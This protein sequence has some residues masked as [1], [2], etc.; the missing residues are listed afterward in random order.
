MD[1]MLDLVMKTQKDIDLLAIQV[2]EV[3]LFLFV[4]CALAHSLPAVA[5][6]NSASVLGRLRY[7]CRLLF[8]HYSTF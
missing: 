1:L 6:T 4:V 8:R 2:F 7:L 5:R 3:A